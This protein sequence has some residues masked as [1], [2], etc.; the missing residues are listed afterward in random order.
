MLDDIAG[1]AIVVGLAI[2]MVWLYPWSRG[3]IS[4]LDCT[5]TLI[6]ATAVTWTLELGDLDA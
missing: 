4:T 3:V 1:E 6:A 2:G 5:R